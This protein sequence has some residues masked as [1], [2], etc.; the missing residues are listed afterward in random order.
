MFPD[1]RPTSEKPEAVWDVIN[2]MA[3][4]KLDIDFP[5]EVTPKEKFETEPLP[6]KRD[7]G[8]I[9]FRHYGKTLER[10]IDK[11]ASMEDSEDKDIMINVI[12]NHMKRL[13]S[14][15]NKEGVDDERIF[16]DLEAFSLGRITINPDTYILD[17]VGDESVENQTSKN[18]AKRK[19]KNNKKKN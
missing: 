13:M 3:D 1:L 10:M 15:H 14:V 2:M 7:S 5:C 6:I 4:F 11:V 8:R 19:K 17:D 16:K 12:A 9:R 18:T